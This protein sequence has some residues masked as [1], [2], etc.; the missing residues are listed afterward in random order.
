MIVM[1]A[2]ILISMNL[3]ALVLTALILTALIWPLCEP[4]AVVLLKPVRRAE[5]P[6]LRMWRALRLPM[7]PWRSE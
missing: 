3:T 6:L 7:Q 4:C 2:S 5:P 1:T